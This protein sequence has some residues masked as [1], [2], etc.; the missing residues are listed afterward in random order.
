MLEN[1]GSKLNKLEDLKG[2]LFSKNYK[3]KLEHRDSFPHFQRKEV[4]VSWEKKEEVK[5]DLREKFFMKTSMFKKLFIFSIVFF[6]LALGYAAYTF[7]ANSNSVSSD[8]IDISVQS[9]TFTA[10]GEEYPLLVQIANKNS[11][12]L[13]LVDLVVDYPKSSSSDSSTDS[14]HIRL[15]LGTIPAGGIKN[16]NVNLVLFGEQGSTQQ[17]KISIEY[18]VQ[19]SNAI[20]VKDKLFDVTISSTPV[21]LS[22][23]APTEASPNQNVNFNVK[24]T[25]NST[26]PVPNMLLKVD[27]P[28]G[29]QFVSATPAPTLGNNVWELGTMTPGI[30]TNIS[31]VGK[32]ID[33]S[34]GEEKV[35]HV[36]SGSQSATDK[37]NI[38]V[39]FNS[40]DHTIIIN[41]PSIEATL[42]INGVSDTQYA[43]DT[44]TTVQGQ[45]HWV[46]NLDTKI[47]NLKIEAKISGNALDRGTI[48]AG[49]NGFY[50]SSQDTI[51]WDKNSD[52][53]FLEVS[54]GDSGDLSF[55]LSPLSLFSASNGMISSPAINIDVIVTGEQ[56]QDAGAPVELSNEESKTINIISDVG[57]STQAVYHSST[58][59]DTGPL[60]PKAEQKTTYTITWSLSNTANNI[61]KAEV[62]STLPEW[63]NFVG[64][65]SPPNEDLTYDPSTKEIVWNIG[66]IP[67]GTGITDGGR[68]VSFQVELTPSLSQVGTEPVIINDAILTGHDD[69]ANVDVR[70]NKTSLN[71][72]LSN[73]SNFP[74]D[75][76]RV[77]Q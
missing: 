65:F 75:G 10:G 59:I 66:G 33:V 27:Y 52:N 53:K 45:I 47:D 68:Q 48:S 43:V 44:Q 32:M 63:M 12:P 5:S 13:E 16:E 50:D 55:S 40:S 6:V 36:W 62:T 41:K 37:T 25:L 8:N 14:D 28:I 57:L 58:F 4:P 46:N 20:F 19:D 42:S 15:S 31:I 64:P 70:V 76:S 9:N 3:V 1:D 24:A 51:I 60:P 77:V 56:A 61:S 39:V 11:S 38:D 7:F 22:V 35:F 69:F 30:G 17:L 73:D 74:L 67:P 72:R 2:R 54:P 18:R 23:D 71:T 29:F 34:E 26:T 21:D 49:N